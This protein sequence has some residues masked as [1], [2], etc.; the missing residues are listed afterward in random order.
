MI[1]ANIGTY[2]QSLPRFT[3]FG[4]WLVVNIFTFRRIKLLNC[5]IGSLS[6]NIADVCTHVW[7]LTHTRYV[8]CWCVY[9]TGVLAQ[10]DEIIDREE[11]EKCCRALNKELT[12]IDDDIRFA[13][14]KL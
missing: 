10:V 6:Q 14:H 1:I 4:C 7:I 9:F 13:V 3:L 2:G 5:V 8:K 11:H 12:A